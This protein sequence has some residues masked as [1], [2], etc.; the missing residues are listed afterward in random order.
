LCLN[1]RKK[2]DTSPQEVDF[3]V[4]CLASTHSQEG[5]FA[6]M[7]ILL[8]SLLVLAS[9]QTVQGATPPNILFVLADDFGMLRK[10]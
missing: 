9:I 6:P 4:K 5:L 8:K 1:N 3:S 10:R 2:K 7:L